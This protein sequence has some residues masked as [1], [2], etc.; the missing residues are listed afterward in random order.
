MFEEILTSM[1]HET[2]GSIGAGLAGPDGIPVEQC[3]R[4]GAAF[5]PDPVAAEMAGVLKAMKK[6]A[7]ILEIG[8]LEEVSLATEKQG[9]L[10]RT[11]AADH[12]IALVFAA[13]G[14]LGKGRYVM[15]RD[16]IKILEELDS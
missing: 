11:V 2:E 10:M 3:T 9:I 1:I 8:E 15:S 12:F 6:A 5:H 16:R 13:G 7:K 14:N 4:E